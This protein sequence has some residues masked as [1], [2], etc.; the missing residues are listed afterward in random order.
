MLNTQCQNENFTDTEKLFRMHVT[1][2][3]ESL[4]KGC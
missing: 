1:K 3:S 2:D 4:E